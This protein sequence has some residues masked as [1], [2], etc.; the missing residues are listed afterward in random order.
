MHQN[1][2]LFYT[3]T[4]CSLFSVSVLIPH[5]VIQA[6]KLAGAWQVEKCRNLR[7]NLA[8]KDTRA[9]F[10]NARNSCKYVLIAIPTLSAPFIAEQR[11]ARHAARLD[12]QRIRPV[13]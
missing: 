2:P 4:D 8:G 13:A 11:L 3:V 6:S 9:G 10:L 5:A 12:L 1:H 7:Q